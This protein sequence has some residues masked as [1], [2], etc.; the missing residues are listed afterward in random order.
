MA[1]PGCSHPVLLGSGSLVMLST[2]LPPTDGTF[3][4][5]S[6][7]NMVRTSSV[8]LYF[9]ILTRRCDT[10]I[11]PGDIVH[12][13]VLGQ[14]IVIL[15]SFKATREL[16][17]QRSTIYNDRPRTVLLGE[18]CDKLPNFHTKVWTDCIVAWDGKMA[19]CSVT[20]H[21]YG[22]VN[23][24]SLHTISARLQCEG[25]VTCSGRKSGHAS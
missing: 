13:S 22:S 19:S 21:P 5:A 18:R 6:K 7:R 1:K 17:Q 23:G 8:Y 24:R 11:P 9:S 20:T 12:L 15:N 2:C 3:T 16:L 10:D 14:D 4:A 25:T